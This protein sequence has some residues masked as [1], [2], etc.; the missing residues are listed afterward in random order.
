MDEL[1]GNRTLAD[2]RSDT[3]HRAVTHVADGED[4][5]N[6]RLEQE[7][8]P[9]KRPAFGTLPVANQVGSGQ[10]KTA[11]VPL[12]KISEPVGAGKCADKN[13]NRTCGHPLHRIAI[14][15]EDRYFF[16]PRVA[17]N[18]SHSSMRPHLNVWRL[19]NLV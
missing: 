1:H 4:S 17:V 8:I 2:S 10:D 9:V 7:R 3:L 12:N 16:Q 14:G 13:K 15:A 5:G 19:F 6:V 18:F 11:I